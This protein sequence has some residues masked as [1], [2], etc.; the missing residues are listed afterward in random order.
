MCRV[1]RFSGTASLDWRLELTSTSWDVTRPAYGR[2]CD[3]TYIV[4]RDP[5]GMPHPD[6]K[7]DLYDPTHGAKVRLAVSVVDRRTLHTMNNHLSY[8][9]PTTQ[10]LG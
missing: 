5:A 4:G 3:P 10:M 6:T 1:Y 7:D 9:V 8:R 2:T